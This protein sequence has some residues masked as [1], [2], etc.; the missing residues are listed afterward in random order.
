MD[1]TVC[2][3]SRSWPSNTGPDE[4]VAQQITSEPFTTSAGSAAAVT[5][6]PNSSPK[7][8]QNSSRCAREGLYTFMRC[9]GRASAS[10]RAW[11]SAWCPVPKRPATR[12]SG[13]ASRR[14]AAPL[15]APT[16]KG[17]MVPSTMM[18]SNSAVSRL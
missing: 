1:T 15:V 11:S 3:G 16:R 13:R 18:P 8:A 12:E 9:S 4:L 14:T 2:P 10:A 7:R 5:G 6:I 17:E